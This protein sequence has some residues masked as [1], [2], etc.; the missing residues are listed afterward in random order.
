MSHSTYGALIPEAFKGDLG[1]LRLIS[2]FIYDGSNLENEMNVIR[3]NSFSDAGF[4]KYRKR[5]RR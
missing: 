1:P 4:E 2:M 5:T 3:Q